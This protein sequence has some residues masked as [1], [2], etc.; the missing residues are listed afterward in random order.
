MEIV[1]VWSWFSFIV[2][3]V[4]TLLVSIVLVLAAAF[5]QWKNQKKQ[6]DSAY[7]ARAFAAWGGRDNSP[8]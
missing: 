4:G 8:R 6:A 3:V 1:I 7:E 5:K 2:G